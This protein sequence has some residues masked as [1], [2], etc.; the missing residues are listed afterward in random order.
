MGAKAPAMK[1][2]Y[3]A[4]LL[5][6]IPF[7]VLLSESRQRALIRILSTP[8]KFKRK[9]SLRSAGINQNAPLCHDRPVVI[10]SNATVDVSRRP[11]ALRR[12]C[13][14]TPPAASILSGWPSPDVRLKRFHLRH[15]LCSSV[16]RS[17]N[18]GRAAASGCTV[19]NCS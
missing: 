16:D 15:I 7:M 14:Q 2:R 13:I 12:C 18:P 17:Q 19:E 1:Q 4:I 6:K 11:V 10:E 5:K 9:R 3:E 8:I